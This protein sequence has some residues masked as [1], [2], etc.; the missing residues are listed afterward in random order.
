MQISWRQRGLLVSVFLSHSIIVLEEPGV[1]SRRGFPPQARHQG[2]GG[3]HVRRGKETPEQGKFSEKE[4]KLTSSTRLLLPEGEKKSISLLARRTCVN[5][6]EGDGGPSS[7]VSGT[8]FSA[9]W[10]KAR[11]GDNKPPAWG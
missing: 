3:K 8:C 11:L 6:F 4:S 7:T 1:S 9:A 5:T 2:A 10:R